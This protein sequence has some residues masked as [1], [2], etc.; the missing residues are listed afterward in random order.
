V[1]HGPGSWLPRAG[2]TVR[3]KVTREVVR[4]H[5]TRSDDAVVM[6]AVLHVSFEPKTPG[7]RREIPYTEIVWYPLVELEPV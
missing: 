2:D 6:C 1:K 5:Q 4:V 7:E 3:I